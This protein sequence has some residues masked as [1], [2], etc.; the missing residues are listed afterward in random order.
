MK[1]SDV[2]NIWEVHKRMFDQFV[3]AD[4]DGLPANTT[5]SLPMRLDLNAL[6]DEY[7]VLGKLLIDGLTTARNNNRGGH[8]NEEGKLPVYAGVSPY[9]EFG[10]LKGGARLVIDTASTREYISLHYSTFYRVA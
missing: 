4:T 9:Q 1:E 5:G 2:V 6:M 3:V 10:Y 7:Y 8:A